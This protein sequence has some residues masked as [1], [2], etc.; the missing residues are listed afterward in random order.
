MKKTLFKGRIWVMTD[1]DGK[2][3]D[4][5]DTDMIYHN[6]HL[7]VT[8]ISE[9]GQYAFGNLEGWEDFSKNAQPDDIVI[10]GKNFGSGSSR[11]H[12]VDCFSALG[13]SA[14]IAESYGAI[15][16]R[17]AINAGFPILTC[18]ALGEALAS[19]KLAHG[20]EIELDLTAGTLKDSG[21][22]EIIVNAQPF[23][24]VQMDIYQAGNVFE[25]GSTIK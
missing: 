18:P 25:Y 21:N 1:S 8:K 17:N 15:Y 5:I 14:L 6:A 24:N 10:V 22:A 20:A 19:G 9:M 4:D 12:A 3:F 16:K 23:S 7:A 11:Q 2:L 13:V